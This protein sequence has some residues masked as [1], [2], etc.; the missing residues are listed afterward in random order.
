MAALNKT[1]SRGCVF[2]IGPP[3]WIKKEINSTTVENRLY[4]PPVFCKAIGIS[5]PCTVTLK[6]SMSST[7]TWQAR[8]APYQG[9]SHH[10]SGLGWTGRNSAGRTGSRWVMSAP[11]RSLKPPCG[12]SSSIPRSDEWALLL[13]CTG[14]AVLIMGVHQ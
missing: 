11:S 14:C 12:M 4:L 6:T 13:A 5:K 2:G 1:S 8:V 3:A 7:R 10:V 9:T